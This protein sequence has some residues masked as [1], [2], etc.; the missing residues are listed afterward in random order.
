MY[1]L[2]LAGEDDAF[3]V[4]EAGV[5]AAGVE[6]IA[7]GV[8]RAESVESAGIERL[9]YTRRASSVVG[10]GDATA[11]A[12]RRI[13]EGVGDERTGSVAV[14]A[15]TARGV[16]GPTRAAERAA[17]EALVAQG[18]T[19]DLETPDHVFRVVFT[20]DACLAGWEVAA[21]R[22]GYGTRAP[23]DRPFFQPGS[24]SPLDAR[25]C[26]NLAGA[27]EGRCVVDPM[28]GTG[29]T[30]IEAALAGSRVVGVD[31]QW[32]MVRGTRENLRAYVGRSSEADATTET[33]GEMTAPETDGVDATETAGS[34]LG[35]VRGDATQLPLAAGSADG[36]VFDAPYGR[37]SKIAGHELASLVEGALQEAA[38]IGSRC[39]VIAD[40][41]WEEPARAAGWSVE[42]VYE[43]PVHRS[44]TRYVHVLR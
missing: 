10:R 19:V 39:V 35:V 27:G 6:R 24:M 29:G 33:D 13:A 32:K 3:A 40:R 16:A 5:A 20:R 9:A 37:Q 7:P 21:S 12:A 38:R 8:A 26:A 42:S 43:R 4:G 18:F 25:A 1:V 28:C 2:E 22:R 34:V 44:L 14:R 23:T 11:A 15:E 36:V 17:G 41:R 31:R 30:L